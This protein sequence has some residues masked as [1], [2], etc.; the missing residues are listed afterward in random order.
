[1]SKARL[2]M[3]VVLATAAMVTV[4]GGVLAPETAFAAKKKAPKLS[5][6]VHAPLVAAQDAMG[7]QDWDTAYA[8]IVEAD[9]VASK[10]D[11]DQFMINELGWF[12][13]VQK[14]QYDKAGAALEAVIQSGYVAEED[15]PA[16]YKPLAQ[17][18]G[19]GEDY[20]KCIEY[21][22]KYLA[23]NPTDS[24]VALLVAQCYNLAENYA[25]TRQAVQTMINNG[26]EPT[27]DLL[28]QAL[29]ASNELN[30]Q[31]GIDQ[32]L[33]HL[34]RLY[35]QQKYW[36]DLLNTELYKENSDRE[37][38]ALYR[39][40]EDTDTL[41]KGD[42][43]SEMGNVLV[44]AG[45]PLEAKRILER[46]MAE[47]IYDGTSKMSATAALEQANTDAAV[48]SKEL[49]GAAGQLASAKNGNQKIAVGKL[50]FSAGEYAKA[51]DAINQ[52]LAA[53]SVTDVDDAQMLLGIAYA[54]AGNDE[55]ARKAFD[56]VS[57]ARM[58]Q[59]AKLW[60]LHLDTRGAAAA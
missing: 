54:R 48:D 13:Y 33:Y 27:E 4:A 40:M 59:I 45:Y 43:F 14:E 52:G 53:G 26:A 3:M 57:N 15:L 51:A 41:D 8:S 21:G 58:A 31:P 17:I 55:A 47:N 34:V 7:A 19:Q 6:D 39:L 50:Y 25:G 10:T 36:E 11:Y 46:G 5:A 37:L 22:D 9:A 56:S 24:G 18:S 60:K 1:M 42:E 35:P 20:P 49:P 12:V 16:R 38:R 28:M 29:I 44:S 30:D 23:T 32:S 2:M